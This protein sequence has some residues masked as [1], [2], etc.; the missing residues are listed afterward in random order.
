MVLNDLV[1]N[2]VICYFNNSLNYSSIGAIP[3]FLSIYLAQF[4]IKKSGAP[5]ENI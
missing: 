2:A 3:P 1:E 5:F 4:A